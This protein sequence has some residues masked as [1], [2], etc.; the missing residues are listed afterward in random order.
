MKLMASRP[1]R[2][3]IFS[4]ATFQDLKNVQ[5]DLITRMCAA[6]DEQLNSLVSGEGGELNSRTLKRSEPLLLVL[7]LVLDFQGCPCSGS[8]AMA[9][10]AV[11]FNCC[12]CVSI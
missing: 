4:V 11:S 1:Y 9:P 7:V 12:M 5:E 8:A 2:T 3:H 6:V 10:I